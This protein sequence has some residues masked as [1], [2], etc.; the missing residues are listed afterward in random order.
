MQKNGSVI[1]RSNLLPRGGKRPFTFSNIMRVLVR[2][3]KKLPTSCG[4]GPDSSFLENF[5]MP[6]SFLTAAE[7][8]MEI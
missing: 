1:M 2:Q 5:S 8:K 4:N 7:M 6:R 3:K